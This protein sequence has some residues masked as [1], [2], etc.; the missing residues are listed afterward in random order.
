MTSAADRTRTAER[1]PRDADAT[2]QKILAAA[3][4][5]FGRY[6]F[7]GA[8]LR[9]IVADAGVNVAAANYHFGSKARLLV[10]TIDHY[11]VCTHSRRFELLDAARRVE[12]AR[13]RLRALIA[14]YLRPHFEMTVGDGNA[15][16][17][18]LLMKVVSEDNPT[19]QE[20]IDRALLPVRQRFREELAACCPDASAETLART[21][22]LIVAVLAMGPFMIDPESLAI[23]S[24]RT[25]PLERA[26]DEATGFAY[27]GAAELLGLGA[28]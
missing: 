7:E 24:L 14:A 1:R 28:G 26:L 15:D 17:A 23:R 8:S 6:G 20:E 27:A 22:G 18:R 9:R 5:H 2:R 25:E 13:P 21:I 12:G 3:I 11:I 4:R 10:A 16:Y 19:L